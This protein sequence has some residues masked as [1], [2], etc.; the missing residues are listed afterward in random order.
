MSCAWRLLISP[1]HYVPRGAATRR[2]RPVAQARSRAPVR[3][4]RSENGENHRL[5]RGN[6]KSRRSRNQPCRKGPNGPSTRPFRFRSQ[7]C[8]RLRA[9]PTSSRLTSSLRR[10]QRPRRQWPTSRWMRRSR[11]PRPK[12]RQP[13]RRG[14]PRRRFRNSRAR[15]RGA[16]GLL[17]RCDE[18]LPSARKTRP[19]DPA[20]FD[21]GPVWPPVTCR[22]LSAAP[23]RRLRAELPDRRIRP[24]PPA[25]PAAA[26]SSASVRRTVTSSPRAMRSASASLRAT[27][28]VIETS[29]SGCRSSGTLYWPM[30]LIGALS[31]TCER[32]ISA[33][34]ALMQARRCRAAKPSRTTG[35]FRSPAG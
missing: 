4:R 12:R 10:P 22:L 3:H 8:C 9:P 11:R 27:I 19:E 18:R 15:R 29:T 35:R 30:V 6:L 7:S 23:A 13:Y 2:A 31:T 20:G 26:S 24:Q 32:L 33:P 28:T 17:Q 21:G 34:S 16:T 1:P 14:R 25:L 5:P